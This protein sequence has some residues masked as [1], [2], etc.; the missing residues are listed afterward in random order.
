M[1]C[2]CV[3]VCMCM[4]AWRKGKKGPGFPPMRMCAAFHIVRY[5]LIFIYNLHVGEK[6]KE[7]NEPAGGPGQ[8]TTSMR[9]NSQSQGFF[10]T[11][12]FP[13]TEGRVPF[14]IW[15]AGVLVFFFFSRP[16]WTVPSSCLLPAS[17]VS[18]SSH[19]D[20]WKK[21][22]TLALFASRP[23]FDR[24]LNFYSWIFNSPL[25]MNGVDWMSDKHL[26][27]PYMPPR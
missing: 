9:S 25:F 1:A 2:W 15:E 7:E 16:Q 12:V 6:K 13:Y 23:T 8:P 24:L 17:N 27:H 18:H 11:K 22:T 20:N 10:V 3:C 14:A 5:I 4:W 26:K 21:K 19:I